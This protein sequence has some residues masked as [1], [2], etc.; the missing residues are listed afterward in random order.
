MT[1]IDPTQLERVLAEKNAEIIAIETEWTAKTEQPAARALGL[2]DLGDRQ[3]WNRTT[4][5]RYLE[6]ATTYQDAFLPKLRRLHA[7]VER[8][9]KLR[10]A[11][12]PRTVSCP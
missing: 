6:A 4:W 10:A 8:L 12:H 2:P 11:Y 1:A 5:N 9:E 3:N 7:E